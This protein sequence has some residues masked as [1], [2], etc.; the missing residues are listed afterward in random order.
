M[1]SK[2]QL[3]DSAWG[4]L[5]SLVSTPYIFLI[6]NI[7]IS[8]N[9]YP[10]L[11]AFYETAGFIISIHI[12]VINLVLTILLFHHTDKHLPY[13]TQVNQSIS[14]LIFFFFILLSFFWAQYKSSY[15]DEIIY[16]TQAIYLYFTI[17]L[18]INSNTINKIERLITVFIAAGG[19]IAIASST[20]AICQP[21]SIYLPRNPIADYLLIPLFL[22]LYRLNTE[23]NLSRRILYLLALLSILTFIILAKSRAVWL[24]S[25]ASLI[26]L[27]VFERNQAPQALRIVHQQIWEKLIIAL[28]IA[29]LIIIS[30]LYSV[31]L[32]ASNLL[33]L[34][35]VI[36]SLLHFNQGSIYG[37]FKLWTNSILILKDHWLFGVGLNNWRMVYP[38]YSKKLI[39]DLA[40]DGRPVNFYLKLAIEIGIPGTIAFLAYLGGFFT[41][42]GLKSRLKSYIKCALF[43]I[44][45]VSFFHDLYPY[46]L[47]IIF[48]LFIIL[49]HLDGQTYVFQINRNILLTTCVLFN[50]LFI[51][52]TAIRYKSLE[53]V[54]VKNQI[55]RRYQFP[56]SIKNKESFFPFARQYT[57]RLPLSKIN[58]FFI[59]VSSLPYEPNMYF[60]LAKK[61]KNSTKD[62]SKILYWISKAAELSPLDYE[63]INLK[64]DTELNLQHY[65]DAQKT[66]E[67]YINKGYPGLWIRKLLGDVYFKTNYKREALIQ[68]K[69]AKAEFNHKLGSITESSLFKTDLYFLNRN[70]TIDSIDSTQ[71]YL[72]IKSTSDILKKI[73]STPQY[74]S[75]LAYDSKA[76]LIYF[77]ANLLGD[78]DL[79]SFNPEH[80][81]LHQLTKL[82]DQAPFKISFSDVSK[83]IY[84]TSDWQ[85]NYFYNIF[86]FDINNKSMENIT[87]NNDADTGEY[88]ISPDG[89]RIAYV[90]KKNNSANLYLL[91]NKFSTPIPL[92]NDTFSKTDLDWSPNNND[93][94]YVCQNNNICLYHI[95]S[96]SFEIIVKH[97]GDSVKMLNF[98]KDGQHL[99]F[100]SENNEDSSQ[101]FEYNFKENNIKQLTQGDD[102]K[103][104]PTF[105]D[106][107]RIIY[108]SKFKDNLLLHLLNTLTGTDTQI[109]P[110]QGV[111]FGTSLISTPQEILFLFSDNSTPTTI[112]SLSL[113]N[114][115]FK[116]LLKLDTVHPDD[117][118]YPQRFNL[119]T[120]DNTLV[121]IYFFPPYHYQTTKTYPTIIWFHDDQEE[122]SPH[123]QNYSQYFA[124]NGYAV[125]AINYRK[126]NTDDVLSLTKLIEQNK[127]FQAS[128][129]Y[130]A[131]V[132]SGAIIIEKTLKEHPELFNGA[133]EWAGVVNK[134]LNSPIHNLPPM[135]IFLGEHDAYVNNNLKI[136][137]ISIQNNIGNHL[138][139]TILKAEGHDF[140]RQS[141]IKRTL[142][143]TVD[144]FNKIERN[145]D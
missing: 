136:Q 35:K 65:Q 122:F 31:E 40:S 57:N 32:D 81:T 94:V 121:P 62:N 105:I 77:S 24:G 4:L 13:R 28:G 25:L 21:I 90:L 92:T 131:G 5:S 42:K 109:G 111:V 139:F 97:L 103:L 67:S 51:F 58:E 129:I 71:K 80:A 143:E 96:H 119:K 88:K 9:I 135:K 141:N 72:G 142:K 102:L 79:Y 134:Y 127:L 36:K 46:F 100:F 38:L 29:F 140:R 39:V 89:E 99:L 108:I 124:M 20:V 66:C 34:D 19:I 125:L 74:N 83:K 37:R 137:Q 78:Y 84:F 8:Q 43:S 138:V 53:I 33:G 110:T 45:F 70:S 69:I 22:T 6:G 16:W 17:P 115:T 2:K 49:N 68:Y 14:L 107:K 7:I 116:R 145:S 75:N 133:V 114:Y 91:R 60:F 54:V 48:L 86:D 101:I 50:L 123:W 12:L 93:L 117:I 52:Q 128:Y 61:E 23:N 10:S 98:S 126:D 55:N 132:G 118:I 73:E 26:M 47:P 113:N 104:F 11:Y 130:L 56:Q 27:C 3:K 41:P 95:V 59:R 106:D 18:L 85:G 87:S 63:T 15:I 30:I 82:A 76:K 44:L 112:C 144:F 1:I 64:A 120:V